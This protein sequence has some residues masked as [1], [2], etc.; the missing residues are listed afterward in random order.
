[1]SVR[2]TITIEDDAAT[3]AREFASESGESLGNAI[4]LLIRA[5][6]RALREDV[7]Y[8]GDFQPAPRRSNGP[9][10]TSERVRELDD[11]S[12]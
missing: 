4:T 9:L 3:I 12:W 11:E 7:D 1:M 6:S 2:T 5:G 8:P 10:I